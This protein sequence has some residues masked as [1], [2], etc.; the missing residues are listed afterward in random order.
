MA[1]PGHPGALSN[2]CFVGKCGY[3]ADGPGCYL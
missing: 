1:E 2:T 3:D